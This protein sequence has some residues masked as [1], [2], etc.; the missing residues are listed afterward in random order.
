MLDLYKFNDLKTDLKLTLD[1]MENK[2]VAM[3]GTLPRKGLKSNDVESTLHYFSYF[4]ENYHKLVE[5][6]NEKVSLI[7][8]IKSGSHHYKLRAE[9]DNILHAA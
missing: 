7:N 9:V 1:M 8:A 5:S 6:F 2:V 4:S 3:Q